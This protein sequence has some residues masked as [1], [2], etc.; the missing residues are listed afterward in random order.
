VTPSE[1]PDQPARITVSAERP[2]N[3]LVGTHL[4]AELPAMLGPDAE[5]VAVIHPAALRASAEAVREDLLGAGY[6]AILLETPDAEDAK[7]AQVA[8]FCWGVLGQAGFT[9]SD[10]IVG[11]GG[12]A[13]TDLAGFVAATWLRGVR[14]VHVPTT[15]LA[16]VDAA[17]GGKTGINTAEGKNLVG[18]IHE[19]AGVL[20]DLN[21]LVTLPRN[22]LV[23]GMAEV[24]K[25]GF[26][27]DTTIL[28]V[29]L[30]D[31]AAA[32]EPTSPVLR[33]LVERS[34]RVKAD[35]VAGDL[36]ET[37]RALGGR[38]IL[39]Y[40][41]TLGHAIE[42]AER[43]RWRHGAAVAVG[44]VFAAELAFL[45]GRIGEHEVDLHRK[46]LTAL[47]LPTTYSGAPWP[48]LHEAM[49]VDKKARG[50]R[51]RFIILDAI[52]SPIFLDGPDPA[53]L[54]GAFDAIS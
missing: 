47:G 41:H 11:L 21:A 10:A 49:M 3:V 25:A 39:N 27:R 44:M 4:L 53:L 42:R 9:R 37:S 12:G 38:E 22:D 28:D 36:R 40:G 17:V 33:E 13:T 52:G 35:V 46:V 6:A 43:Y 16:M 7:T 45:A 26:I 20:C 19:P 1:H 15:L 8:A 29:V 2:Y 31:P 51:L 5:R 48:Q 50:S 23:A 34:I 14:V 30:A 18:A 54:L 24:V 32:T